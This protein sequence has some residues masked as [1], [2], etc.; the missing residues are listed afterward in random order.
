MF[1]NSITLT[2]FLSYGHAAEPIALGPLNVIIG[3]N[4]SGKSNL[5]EAIELLR[6]TPKDLLTPIRDGG[7]VRDW[8]WKGA[9]KLAIATIDAVIAYPK[10]TMPI[11]YLLSFTETGQRFEI[12]DERIENEAPYQGQPQ[13]L[14]FYRFKNGR[15][16]LNL[17]GHNTTMHPVD[18][19][20][21]ASILSQRK[22]PD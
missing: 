12:T 8:L 1:L 13:S 19:D 15:G 3:P 2:N 9:T 22:D 21:A 6:A 4:G 20:P 10:Q 18:I 11:R 7:G 5:I 17:K 16:L 14:Y